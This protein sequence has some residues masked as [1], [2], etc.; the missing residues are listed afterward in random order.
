MKKTNRFP[1]PESL[2]GRPKRGNFKLTMDSI[3]K[4]VYSEAYIQEWADYKQD[5]DV[6]YNSMESADEFQ[7]Y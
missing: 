6:P 2:I 5:V 1:I 4:E 3:I 7:L